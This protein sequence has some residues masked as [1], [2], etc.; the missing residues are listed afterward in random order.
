MRLITRKPKVLLSDLE[1]S[2]REAY[3]DATGHRNGDHSAW[4][5]GQDY[6]DGQLDLLHRI[7]AEFGI[8]LPEE[9]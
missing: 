1:D 6:A 3:A 9:G 8:E 2:L 5:E 7:A 4:P